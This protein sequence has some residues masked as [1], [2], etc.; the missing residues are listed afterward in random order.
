MNRTFVSLGSGLAFLAVALGAFGTHTLRDRITP[1]SLQIW[2]TGIQYHL[3][4]AI[5]LI[6]IGIL[7]AHSDEK[8]VKLPGWLIYY[9]ILIFSGSLYILALTD[10]RIF[11][12]ITPLGGV[13]FLSGWGILC[14]RMSRKAA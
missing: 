3:V 5:G 14:W 12:A 2:Q 13:C 10:I 1:A 7:A 6:L 9:G 4:H 11:G 8:T